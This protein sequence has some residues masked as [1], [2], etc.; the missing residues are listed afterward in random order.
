[1]RWSLAAPLHYHRTFCQNLKP[2]SHRINP[3][4]DRILILIELDGGN[5][6]LNTLIPMG[7]PLL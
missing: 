1:M 3:Q 6:G 7:R 2:A 5:D 4:W